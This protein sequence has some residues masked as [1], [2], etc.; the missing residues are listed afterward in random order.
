[1]FPYTILNLNTSGKIQKKKKNA[2][3]ADD[4][5]YCTDSKGRVTRVGSEKCENHKENEEHE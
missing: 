3:D 5:Y 2:K 4:R 1:M